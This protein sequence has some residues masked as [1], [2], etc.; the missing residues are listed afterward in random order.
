[1]KTFSFENIKNLNPLLLIKVRRLLRQKTLRRDTCA[2]RILRCDFC[3]SIKINK[4][5]F[6]KKIIN[7]SKIIGL[8]NEESFAKINLNLF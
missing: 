8:I 7:D 6:N 2:A 3:A 4:L 5:F 1:M